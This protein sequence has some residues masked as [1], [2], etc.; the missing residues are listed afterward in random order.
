MPELHWTLPQGWKESGPGQMSL[1]S[2]SVEDANG[3]ATMN[4]TPLP[5]L[6]GREEAVVNMW[7][8]QVELGPLTAE[9]RKA[10][11]TTIWD[12][13]KQGFFRFT[14]TMPPVQNV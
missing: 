6:E 2:F 9:E 3:S 12:Q 5:N 13:Q 1:A 11:S 7:R 14:L 8:E 10:A 4:I